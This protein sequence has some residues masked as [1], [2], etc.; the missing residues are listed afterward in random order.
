[1]FSISSFRLLYRKVQ[2]LFF[3]KFC[4]GCQKQGVDI[5]E[6]C[7]KKIEICTRIKTIHS[8]EVL[9]FYPYKSFCIQ[10]LIR[11]AK[12]YYLPNL[13]VQLTQLVE[14][15]I[16][17]EEIEGIF[18]PIPLYILREKKRGF[19]QSQCIAEQFSSFLPNTQVIPL[20]KR[21]KN[22][23]HQSHKNKA[24]REKNIRGAFEVNT[25]L[26]KNLDLSTPVYLIDD[27]VS[28]GSTL[29][30]AKKKLE[31]YGFLEIRAITLAF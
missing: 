10:T 31:E 24:D 13:L 5:C 27:V 2:N 19:N 12:F 30:E 9:S 6:N 25:Q 7:L 20:L 16:Q 17:Q 3:P 11:E 26:M 23:N 14:P 8:L 18:I 22:T 4:Y 28:T 29:L 21:I 1:M 15:E